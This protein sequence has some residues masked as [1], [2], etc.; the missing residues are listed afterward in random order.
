MDQELALLE[1]LKKLPDFDRLPLPASWYKK[2]NIPPQTTVGPKEYIESNYA[3]R[4]AIEPKDLPPIVI[5]K[6]QTDKDG[7]VILVEMVKVEEPALEVRAKPFTLKE[8]EEFP[9]ILVPDDDEIVV[10]SPK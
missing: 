3:M 6:P 4:M 1:E 9:A 8:G 2:Y 7:N 5:T 10:R